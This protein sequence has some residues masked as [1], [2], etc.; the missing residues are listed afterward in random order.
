MT[1]QAYRDGYDRID[2]SDAPKPKRRWRHEFASKRSHLACPQIVR[3]FSDPV[4]SMADGKFY[5]DP[6]SLRATYKAENNP[7]GVDYIELGNERQEFVPVEFDEKQ[8]RD[9][10]RRSLND[11]KNGNVSPEIAAIR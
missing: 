4:Q 10:I 1:T 3:P 6:A 2:W 5:D 11:V 9:D 8:R 7:R